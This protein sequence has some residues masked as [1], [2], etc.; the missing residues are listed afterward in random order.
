MAATL[1]LSV[2]APSESVDGD[3]TDEQVETL[4]ARAAARL[5][6]NPSIIEQDHKFKFPKLNTGALAQPYITSDNGVA[7]LDSARLLEGRQRQQANA[8]KK[9]ED[10]VAA[11]R[12]AVEVCILLPCFIVHPVYEENIPNIF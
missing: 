4:L 11:K 6:Q 8:M 3:L 9:V 2:A 12:L 7:Q 5:S 10:P 1:E